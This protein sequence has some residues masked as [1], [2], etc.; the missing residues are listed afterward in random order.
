MVLTHVHFTDGYTYAATDLVK[1][2]LHQESGN[3]K[4]TISNLWN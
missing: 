1:Q 2:I 3:R 4:L